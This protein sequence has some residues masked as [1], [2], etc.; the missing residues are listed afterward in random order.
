MIG[1]VPGDDVVCVL[2][3]PSCDALRG[4]LQ[5]M[6]PSARPSPT[7]EEIRAWR[8]ERDLSAWGARALDGDDACPR[9]GRGTGDR[10]V[11]TDTGEAP[12]TATDPADVFA[13]LPRTPCE[14]T[15]VWLHEVKSIADP[16][17]RHRGRLVRLR[18][19]PA[20]TPKDRA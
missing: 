5:S 18:R 17:R 14:P 12:R 11:L 4:R 20:P 1:D 13:C 16:V 15:H 19:P 6:E 3:H 10:V 8:R 9:L 2:R 7:H